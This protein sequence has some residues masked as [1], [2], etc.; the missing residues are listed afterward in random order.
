MGHVLLNIKK[1]NIM[2]N[3]QELEKFWNKKAKEVLLGKTI[4]SVNYMTK[5]DADKMYWGK[6]P[7]M[8]KLSDGTT[9]YLSCD[10]EG[11]D[12]GALFYSK[13]GNYDELPVL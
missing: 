5:N 12:G 8:F 3:D 2:K 11:N 4:V 1:L 9:C 6:R 7:V 13:N 10:D